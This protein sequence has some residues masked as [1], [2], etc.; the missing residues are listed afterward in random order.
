LGGDHRKTIAVFFKYI[1]IRF[2]EKN[3]YQLMCMF[4]ANIDKLYYASDKVVKYA[5]PF[6]DD[7]RT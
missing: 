1:Q 4:S 2:D 6:N 3:S 5:I 7:D